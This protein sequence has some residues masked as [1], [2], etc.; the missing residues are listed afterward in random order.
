MRVQEEYKKSGFFWLPDN[1]GNKIPGTLIIHDGGKIELEV[2]GL[3]D[4]SIDALNGDD[5]LRRIIG[6]VEQDGLVTLED[7]FY[8]N[9]NI[10]FGGI[11]K[12]K[13]LVHKVLSGAAWD[14]DEKVTF[15]TLSFS[16]DCLDEWVGITGINVA[17]SGDYKTA[18]IGYTP[19]EPFK[20]ALD[21]GMELSIC[22]AYTLPSFPTVNEARITQRAY[23]KISSDEVR[24]LSEFT[25][26]AYK[27]TNLLCFA[28]DETVSLKTLSATSNEIKRNNP[29]QPIKIYYQSIPYAEKEPTKKRYNMLFSFTTIQEN[30]GQI[31]NNWI[32][33]YEFL[34]PALGLYFSTK[35]GAHKYLDG[36]FLALAQGLETYH[37]RT[38]TETLMDE[39]DFRQLVDDILESCPESNRDWLRGRLTHGNEINLNR[40]LK[41]IVEPFKEHIGNSKQRG[42]LLRQIVDTRNYLT[43]YSEDLKEL[44]ANGTNLYN[45]CSKME[46]IL[47]LHFLK[48]I[49][50]TDSEISDVVKTSQPLQD[51]INRPLLS[52]D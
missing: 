17:R 6:H 4:D 24:E 14:K 47:N 32:N 45:L 19:P 31:F 49:G 21:N 41:K 44:A 40:R 27:I 26:L 8:T 43:H 30:A 37:R 25:T 29:P 50:F 42:K 46:L 39:N 51:R 2:V 15:N 22:F 33:A 16:I 13:V 7:C 38:S 36:K 28:T 1:E 20:F 12:S 52:P 9:K 48:V 3:F 35:E 23:I 5:N 34:S 11:S 18:T 10:T